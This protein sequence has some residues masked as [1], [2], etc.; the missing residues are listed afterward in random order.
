MDT[1]CRE[2]N[3][4]SYGLNMEHSSGNDLQITANNEVIGLKAGTKISISSSKTP[5]D[6]VSEKS[7]DLLSATGRQD[8]FYGN[9]S[10]SS[11]SENP[12]K[13]DNN[14]LASCPLCQVDFHAL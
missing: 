1:D 2:K 13:P 11:L 4:D 8:R 3:L 6:A 10:A 5:R 12:G 9:E 7:G 14:L